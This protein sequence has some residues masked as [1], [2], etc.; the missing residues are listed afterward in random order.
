MK[1]PEN[2][3]I[4]QLN[5]FHR[6]TFCVHKKNRRLTQ[7]SR[8]QEVFRN[9]EL[10]EKLKSGLAHLCYGFVMPVVILL[11]LTHPIL[12][13]LTKSDVEHVQGTARKD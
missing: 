11:G 12:P 10:F 6:K 4:C 1:S 13:H 8:L 7:C 5:W 3:S 9:P 2:A